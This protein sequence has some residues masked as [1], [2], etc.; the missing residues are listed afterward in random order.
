M[1]KTIINPETGNAVPISSKVGMRILKKYRNI[2]TGGAMS[3]FTDRLVS[4]PLAASSADNFIS[5]RAMVLRNL[6]K[7]QFADTDDDLGLLTFLCYYLNHK[8]TPIDDNKMCLA[9]F[10]EVVRNKLVGTDKINKKIEIM[11]NKIIK[12]NIEKL[13]TF[14]ETLVAEP[15]ED[16]PAPNPGGPYDE[17]QL[18]RIDFYAQRIQL[19]YTTK[20]M[21]E[22]SADI[23]VLVST[24]TNQSQISEEESGAKQT[25]SQMLTDIPVDD[26]AVF[27]G[28]PINMKPAIEALKNETA[29]AF[30][31]AKCAEPLKNRKVEYI[32]ENNFGRK[33]CE[34]LYRLDADECCKKDVKASWRTARK[35]VTGAIRWRKM[36]GVWSPEELGLILDS[37]TNLT[38]TERETYLTEFAISAKHLERKLVDLDIN[39]TNDLG[40]PPTMTGDLGSPPTMTGGAV[41]GEE[42]W[43]IAQNDANEYRKLVM[44]GLTTAGYVEGLWGITVR[45]IEVY[46]TKWMMSSQAQMDDCTDRTWTDMFSSRA[47]LVETLKC[48]SRYGR[49]RSVQGMFLAA[50]HPKTSEVILMILSEYKDQVCAEASIKRRMSRLYDEEAELTSSGLPSAREWGRHRNKLIQSI[51]TFDK[52]LSGEKLDDLF[53]LFK[54]AL[55]G[56]PLLGSI[57]GVF[58]HILLLASKRAMREWA[59]VLTLRQNLHYVKKIFG[60]GCLELTD[61]SRWVY[62]FDMTNYDKYHTDVTTNKRGL[63]DMLLGREGTRLMP[64][65]DSQDQWGLKMREGT[66]QTEGMTD[67]EW[68]MIKEDWIIDYV[69]NSEHRDI[70]M[71]SDLESVYTAGDDMVERAGEEVSYQMDLRHVAYKIAKGE[72]KYFTVMYGLHRGREGRER[73]KLALDA[74]IAEAHKNLDRY[75]LNLD[76]LDE[77]H[78]VA[79]EE[80]LYDD[81]PTI[82]TSDADGTPLNEKEVLDKIKRGVYEKRLKERERAFNEWVTKTRENIAEGQRAVGTST[83][84]GV[85]PGV[86]F[87]QSIKEAEELGFDFSGFN[88]DDALRPIMTAGPKT[89]QSWMD[90]FFLRGM[91][92][93]EVDAHGAGS[94][95]G[96]LGDNPGFR[97]SADAEQATKLDEQERLNDLA[98]GRASLKQKHANELAALEREI[99]KQHGVP[100]PKQEL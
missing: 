69:I 56:I 90:W 95:H 54:S 33:G 51:T 39:W 29:E 49:D 71:L 84:K 61:V 27:G 89:G 73:R 21:E 79:K 25:P 31:T 62:V 74:E 63:W 59:A 32:A 17:A 92:Q 70:V 66:I 96:R 12:E 42:R 36:T 1:Y 38:D 94:A 82:Y 45:Y 85:E 7:S 72:I 88:T 76:E 99:N 46:I 67:E 5:L 57:S 30:K 83:G 16:I 64:E 77:W 97:G 3:W 80:K 15:L 10:R 48:W 43:E 52:F 93:F 58:V 44:T 14:I 53:I 100:T 41:V 47:H 78:G 86:I 22:I 23:P 6:L 28:Y 35:A 50:K 87:A 55:V 9:D 75:K 91:K 18:V 20:V 13:L 19:V 65:R 40:S 2:S 34:P 37:Y 8:I 24:I 60:G 11:I 98:E 4:A 68:D 81:H 26:N